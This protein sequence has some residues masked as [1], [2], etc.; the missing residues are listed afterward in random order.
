MPRQCSV[1]KQSRD[2][3]GS[4]DIFKALNM[5]DKQLRVGLITTNTDRQ[6]MPSYHYL[7]IQEVHFYIYAINAEHSNLIAAIANNFIDLPS[8]TH[9]NYALSLSHTPRKITLRY[10]KRLSVEIFEP[11]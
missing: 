8:G 2:V 5:Y 9:L 10:C 1:K 4:T 11:N 3:S 7:K 6:Q